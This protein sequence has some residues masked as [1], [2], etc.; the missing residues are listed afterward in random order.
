MS[1]TQLVALDEVERRRIKR[2][3]HDGAQGRL[4][5]LRIMS[6]GPAL[7]AGPRTTERSA[8]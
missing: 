2:D 3:L 8:A 5:A 6:N 7:R 1:S 4:I